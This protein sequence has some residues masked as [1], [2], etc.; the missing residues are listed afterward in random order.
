MRGSGAELLRAPENDFVVRFLGL[1]DGVRARRLREVADATE[2]R[3]SHVPGAPGPV[4]A[5]QVGRTAGL[6]EPS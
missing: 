1:D 2:A 4:D 6:G 5:T 3:A